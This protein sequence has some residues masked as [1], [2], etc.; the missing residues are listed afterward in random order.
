VSNGPYSKDKFALDMKKNLD[1]IVQA[2]T[3]GN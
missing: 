2:V 1:T 3:S